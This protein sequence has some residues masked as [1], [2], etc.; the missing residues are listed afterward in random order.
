M[1]SVQRA[2]ET[3]L[4][5]ASCRVAVEE[6]TLI[7]ALGRTLAA[8]VVATIDVPPADNSAMDG[9]ALGMRVVDQTPSTRPESASCETRR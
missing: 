7:G 4:H 9:Y 3:L 1:L 8:D 6:A 5:E 2:V